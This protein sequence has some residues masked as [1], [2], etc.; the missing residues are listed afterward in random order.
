MKKNTI[1][2]TICA[3]LAAVITVTATGCGS[4][5]GSNT[6]SEKKTVKAAT[7]QPLSSADMLKNGGE[8]A[9][10]FC[11]GYTDLSAELFRK[12]CI[13]EIKSGKN[14]MVSPESVVGA[15]GMTANGAKGQTLSEME[16]VL[17]SSVE[18]INTSMN[19]F[20]NK[21]NQDKNIRFHIADSVWVRDDESRVK[22]LP[23]F[24]DTVKGYYGADTFMEPF[25]DS[26]LKAINNW[27]NENTDG[28]IPE[29]LDSIADEACIYLINTAAFDAEWEVPF[30]D[31]SVIENSTFN[32][33]DGSVQECTMLWGSEN[34]YIS[35]DNFTGFSKNYKGGEYSFVA[36]LPEEG[37]DMADFVSSLDGD[38]LT[39]LWQNRSQEDVVITM[40]EFSFD[41]ETELQGTLS[42]MGMTSLFSESCDLSGMSE[43]AKT[44][45]KVI[46]KTHI[47]VNRKGTKAA[48]ATAVEVCD[49]AIALPSKR[50]DLDRPFVYAIYDNYNGVPLFIGAV[51]TLC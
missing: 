11:K 27:V 20:I 41:Y 43:P 13:E 23:E 3:A 37:T 9:E 40:P 16:N 15:L 2:K 22:I 28:M 36:L 26:T 32:A 4:T 1:K 45:S 49:G 30:E 19:Y 50:V 42:D 35:G 47:D 51:N 5:G 48:A 29:L 25:D 34:Y 33:F 12:N 44:V 14:V 38:T 24:A 10:G 17:G 8:P 18:D 6:T 31:G 46:H 39:E 7:A 21:S